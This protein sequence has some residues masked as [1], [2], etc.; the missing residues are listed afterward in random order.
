MPLS[1]APTFKPNV[2]PITLAAGV[3]TS[4]GTVAGTRFAAASGGAGLAH[5]YTFA[6][7]AGASNNVTPAG[8]P[9]FPSNQTFRVIM[10]AAAGNANLTGLLAGVDGQLGYLYNN[11]LNN[12]ITLNNLNA[13]STAANQFLCQNGT[14]ASPNADRILVPRSGSLVL[15]DA[16]IGA[17]IVL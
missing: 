17:W 4:D 16:T 5:R 7:P 1:S 2:P 10:T 14:L 6:A 3:L 12:Q 8:S 9:A 15:Y 13:G 11:D